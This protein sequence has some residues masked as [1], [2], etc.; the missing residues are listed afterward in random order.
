MSIFSLLSSFDLASFNIVQ[1]VLNEKI[2]AQLSETEG[3][4]SW[5]MKNKIH[6]PLLS[7]EKEF[8]YNTIFKLLVETRCLITT[9]SLS[10]LFHGSAHKGWVE[11]NEK[12]LN[13][14]PFYSVIIESMDDVLMND[15][16]NK[17]HSYFVFRDNSGASGDF[18]EDKSTYNTYIVESDAL[19]EKIKIRRVSDDFTPTCPKGHKIAVLRPEVVCSFDEIKTKIQ[20]EYSRVMKMKDELKETISDE[21]ACLFEEGKT[22]PSESCGSDDLSSATRDLSRR[23]YFNEERKDDVLEGSTSKIITM[24]GTEPVQS[25]AILPL[26]TEPIPTIYPHMKLVQRSLMGQA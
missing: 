15:V 8:N 9:I 24:T 6:F 17:E 26:P 12:G 25:R 19:K 14:V 11:V 5:I 10:Y 1:T 16:D 23:I 3:I 4:V 21:Y 20:T 7:K 2:D 22:D 18:K 13:N